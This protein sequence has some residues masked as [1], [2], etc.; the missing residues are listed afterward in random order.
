MT[1]STTAE[2]GESRSSPSG[3]QRLWRIGSS[4]CSFCADELNCSCTY[5]LQGKYLTPL[6]MLFAAARS[7]LASIKFRSKSVHTI[8]DNAQYHIWHVS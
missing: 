1:I 5:A 7:S 4:V 3:G 2:D 8:E 6:V